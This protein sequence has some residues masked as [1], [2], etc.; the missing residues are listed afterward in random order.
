VKLHYAP[1]LGWVPTVRHWQV[2]GE[3]CP[4]LS[5]GLV[6]E[7]ESYDLL[8]A[9]ATALAPVGHYGEPVWHARELVAA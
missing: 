5:G 8:D 3:W 1:A 7:L 6:A 4:A 9:L 2:G